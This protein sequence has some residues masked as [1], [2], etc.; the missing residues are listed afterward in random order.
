M[1]NQLQL[2]QDHAH[3]S[4]QLQPFQD[5]VHYKTKCVEGKAIQFQPFQDHHPVQQ[6]N[7]FQ[8]FQDDQNQHLHC[9]LDISQDLQ[10][11][12]KSMYTSSAKYN[13]L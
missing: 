11:T 3:W 9:I 12:Q 13:H 8:P 6:K 5:H 2:F 7:Q 4:N 1:S 10:K